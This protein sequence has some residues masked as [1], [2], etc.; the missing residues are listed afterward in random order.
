M[1]FKITYVIQ[2]VW[3]IHVYLKSE[4]FVIFSNAIVADISL[5]RIQTYVPIQTAAL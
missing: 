3:K 4:F 2:W 1:L 5:L